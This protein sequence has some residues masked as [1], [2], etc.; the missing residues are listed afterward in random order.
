MPKLT[1]KIDGHTETWMRTEHFCLNCGSNAV[2]TRKDA[3]DYYQGDPYLCSDCS[4][5]WNFTDIAV[6]CLDDWDRQR[7]ECLHVGFFKLQ[8]KQNA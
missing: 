7:L 1:F 5:R 4:A 6:G 2:W 8:T 3:K